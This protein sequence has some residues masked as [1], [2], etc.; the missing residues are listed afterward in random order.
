[1]LQGYLDWSAL[2]SCIASKCTSNHLWI[3]VCRTHESSRGYKPIPHLSLF[4]WNIS[5]IIN[6]SVPQRYYNCASIFT[7]A[8]ENLTG[9]YF[10]SAMWL[11]IY[12]K[13]AVIGN[14]FH[15]FRQFLSSSKW[16]VILPVGE[17]GL[18]FYWVAR[19]F[20]NNGRSLIMLCEVNGLCVGGHLQKMTKASKMAHYWGLTS[21]IF[22]QTSQSWCRSLFCLAVVRVWNLR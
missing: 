22:Y 19:Q 18:I 6:A 13:Q 2:V 16:Q 5:G 20:F 15:V 14:H 17:I 3:I 12:L 4:L 1:M 21:N 9:G 11:V 7:G 10:Y 8:A